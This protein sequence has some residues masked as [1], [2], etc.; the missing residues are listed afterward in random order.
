[1]TQNNDAISYL[2]ENGLS[3]DEISRYLS[4][5]ISAAELVKA[6]KALFPAVKQ[7]IPTIQA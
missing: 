5:G 1:M 6:V 3:S 4:E 7:L 2:M